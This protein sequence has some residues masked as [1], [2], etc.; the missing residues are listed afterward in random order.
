MLTQLSTTHKC[1]F[2]QSK[3]NK[4]RT[5]FLPDHAAQ[6]FS[7]IKTDIEQVYKEHDVLYPF[8]PRWSHKFTEM[9]TKYLKP[10]GQ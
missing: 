3:V 8:D 10:Y 5:V 6:S 7:K 1:S 2:H 9:I 4:Q